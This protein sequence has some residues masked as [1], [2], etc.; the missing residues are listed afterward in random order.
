MLLDIRGCLGAN[1]AHIQIAYWSLKTD[2][3]IAVLDPWDLTVNVK[4]TEGVFSRPN[5]FSQGPCEVRSA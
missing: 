1:N 3:L 2:P 5:A 4:N